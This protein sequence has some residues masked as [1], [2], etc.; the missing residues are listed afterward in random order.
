MCSNTLSSYYSPDAAA[1]VEAP[2][3]KKGNDNSIIVI[4][5]RGREL[6]I[7]CVEPLSALAFK[8]R[9]MTNLVVRQ[10][11]GFV[12]H[13]HSGRPHDQT[14]EGKADGYQKEGIGASL[15]IWY[16]CRVPRGNR[17]A[18]CRCRRKNQSSLDRTLQL[19]SA[20]HVS[21]TP[22]KT[23]HNVDMLQSFS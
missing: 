3:D 9:G 16:Y 2:V 17:R 20:R 5:T 21:D 1:Q 15:R 14:S 7:D 23:Y 18:K 11:C 6:I 13:E 22:P 4:H 8:F 12:N 10:H 19:K